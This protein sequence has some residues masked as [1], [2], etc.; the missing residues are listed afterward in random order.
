MFENSH[1][2]VKL[3]KDKFKGDHFDHDKELIIMLY[4][5]MCPHCI[6]KENNWTNLSNIYNLGDNLDIAACDINQEREI[7]NS[8]GI[9]G[10]PTF[11][12][13]SNNT[14][15]DIPQEIVS[16]LIL[17]LEGPIDEKELKPKPKINVSNP[18][19]HKSLS[20]HKKLSSPQ[21]KSTHK[22]LSSPKHKS[23][24]K[25][26]SSSKNTQSVNSLFF[27]NNENKFG[28]VNLS[29]LSNKSE[30]KPLPQWLSNEPN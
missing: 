11:K 27:K 18:N 3:K 13:Q 16:E 26:R 8:L 10:V 19:K 2:V 21:H 20:T 30:S 28:D 9:H 7:G 4:S 24:S 15:Y 6:R 12:Y 23:T 1:N 29:M 5:P 14:L 17:L 22:S 25:A